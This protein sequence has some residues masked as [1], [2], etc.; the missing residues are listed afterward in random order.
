MEIR[1]WKGEYVSEKQIVWCLRHTVALV[2][3][4]QR[5]RRL[6][7]RANVMKLARK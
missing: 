2:Q 6:G 5:T 3:L 4:F 7:L 1:R